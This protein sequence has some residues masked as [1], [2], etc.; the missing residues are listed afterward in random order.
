M[1]KMKTKLTKTMMYACREGDYFPPF[2]YGFSYFSENEDSLIFHIF[3][4]NIFIK[5]WRAFRTIQFE[6]WRYY[7]MYAKTRIK[8]IHNKGGE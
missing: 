5:L 7:L 6:Q 3:P 8:Y 1:F 4:L 2:Y